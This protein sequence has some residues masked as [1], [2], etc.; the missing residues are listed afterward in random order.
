MLTSAETARLPEECAR[1]S[2]WLRVMHDRSAA[3][4]VPPKIVLL[5]ALGAAIC[6]RLAASAASRALANAAAERLCARLEED[7]SAPGWRDCDPLA[8][9]VAYALAPAETRGERARGALRALGAAL[10][11]GGD[12]VLAGDAL[13]ELALCGGAEAVA[14]LCERIDA[15]GILSAA[16]DDLRFAGAALT[17][18]AFASFRSAAAFELGAKVLRVVAS[19]G[20][21]PM[22]A[23]EGVRLL[24]MQQRVDGSFGDLPPR[25]PQAGDITF[26]FHLPRTAAS[27]WVIHDALAPVSLVRAAA[28]V[29]AA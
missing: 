2:A 23:A 24:R 3:L 14:A 25:S 20:L 7:A 10:P 16:H 11:A 9:A 27:L 19:R 22:G 1:A 12:P 18:R 13:C 8:L 6:D 15:F 26:A 4:R 28:A 21:D 5:I 17:A 29:R